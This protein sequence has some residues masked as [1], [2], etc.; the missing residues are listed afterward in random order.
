MDP[1][2]GECQYRN[3]ID[4]KSLTLTD[5]FLELFVRRHA[6]LGCEYWPVIEC[7]L[8]GGSLENAYKLIS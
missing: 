2:D 7:V 5:T 6:A 1:A 8:N 3:S 4:V